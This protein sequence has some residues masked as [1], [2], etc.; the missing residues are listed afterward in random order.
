LLSPKKYIYHIN[1]YKSNIRIDIFGNRHDGGKLFLFAMNIATKARRHKGTPRGLLLK[2]P[3]CLGVPSLGDKV[4]IV[5]GT[6][7]FF[8]NKML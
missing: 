6:G 3:W 8:D 4:F 1:A 7:D 5:S 2:K